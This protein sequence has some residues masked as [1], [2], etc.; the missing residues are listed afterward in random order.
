VA[1]RKLMASQTNLT[2]AEENLS[3]AEE[4]FK[5]GLISSSDLMAAQTAWLS[6]SSE[7]LDAGIEVQ[8]DYLY[9]QQAMGR[10]GK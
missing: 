10:I 2:H 5:S 1:N 8:M 9:L 7:L 6:A 3:L 4:S